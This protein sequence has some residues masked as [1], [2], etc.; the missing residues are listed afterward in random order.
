MTLFSRR[1][2]I[3]PEL[4]E[5]VNGYLLEGDKG[6][7]SV[8]MPEDGINVVTNPS[9]E[10]DATGWTAVNSLLAC[11]MEQQVRGV[12]SLRITPSS[13][14]LAGTYVTVTTPEEVPFTGSM[15]VLGHPGDTYQLYFIKTNGVPIPAAP[16]IEFQG[17]GRWQRVYCV[18]SSNNDNFVNTRL[19]IVRKAGGSLSPFYIDACQVEAKT[20]PTTYIDGDQTGVIQGSLDFWWAGQPHASVSY[21][22]ACSN[23]GKEVNLKDLGFQLIGVLG[24]SM[25]P[26]VNV[27]TPISTG[28]ELYQRSVIQA[29]EF[30][31]AGNFDGRNLLDFQRVRANIL[32][33]ISP[34]RD[35]LGQPLTLVYHQV[36]NPD[37]IETDTLDFQ[38]SYQSGMEGSVDSLHQDRA[39]IVFKQYMPYFY[40]RFSKAISYDS[41]TLL[42]KNGY[43]YG[44]VYTIQVFFMRKNFHGEWVMDI[45]SNDATL[46]ATSRDIKCMAFNA[47]TGALYVG[48]GFTETSAGDPPITAR[49]GAFDG[50]MIDQVGGDYPS[51]GVVEAIAVDGINNVAYIG[52][53]FT[54]FV[55][56]ATRNR[57]AYVYRDSTWGT[58]GTGAN[59]RV[60]VLLATSSVDPAAPLYAGGLFTL[61]GGVADTVGIA[62]WVPSTA[63]WSPMGTG[64]SNGEVRALAV[65]AQG[66]IYAGGSFTTMGG[67]TGTTYIA[68]WNGTTWE[69][70]GSGLAG[71]G[72]GVFSM[73]IGKDGNLYVGGGFAT[74]GGKASNGFAIW[75]GSDWIAFSGAD[76]PVFGGT[77]SVARNLV[78]DPASGDIYFGTYDSY[79]TNPGNSWVYHNG[80]FHR[81]DTAINVVP[82]FAHPQT[83]DIYLQTPASDTNVQYTIKV[84]NDNSSLIYPIINAHGPTTLYSIRNYTTGKGIYFGDPLIS[85]SKVL[86]IGD[87]ENVAISF[88]PSGGIAIKSNIRGNL[89]SFI[90]PDSDTNFYLV[91]GDNYLSILDGATATV[92]SGDTGTQVLKL[93]L[94]GANPSNTNEGYV[95]LVWTKVG[96][97]SY[98]KFYKDAA[99]T[100]EVANAWL[101]N[102]EVDGTRE[103]PVW[104]SNASG[105]GGMIHFKDGA[106]H[107]GP[108][109]VVIITPIY[110]IT[111]P[112][113]YQSL[114]EASL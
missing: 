31:L 67:V 65:D 77:Y 36:Q 28:G 59:D 64:I 3:Y 4:P 55:S 98:L 72:Y 96:S 34:M 109:P 9:F 53:T 56:T 99:L 88:S 6:W 90:T 89:S 108:T 16:T 29:R 41:R 102:Y 20:Y 35:S 33:L 100:L 75:N 97:S 84:T 106:A 18:M 83:N 37:E 45:V 17:T 112:K 60:N 70:L 61:M 13:T 63:T 43:L 48:G 57:I 73:V 87:G 68:K 71:G 49:F 23:G 86:T 19:Y 74:A 91:V 62:K 104:Q 76:Y 54:T 111:L 38:A 40:S 80:N 44:E 93:M 92:L 79:T 114:D 32:R 105:L 46:T 47:I 24:L 82:M 25:L 12:Y 21:R 81:M 52:G 30:T 101:D 7:F 8:I 5:L 11:T 95:Y 78:L 42:Y 113:I 69:A 58:L 50:D 15:Y 39:A 1:D 85:G 103:Y 51:N 22:R 107:P 14:A 10:I 110:T 27:T 94:T 26:V 66:N 2:R